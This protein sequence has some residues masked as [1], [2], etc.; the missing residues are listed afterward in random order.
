M[1][2]LGLTAALLLSAVRFLLVVQ[3]Q[4]DTLFK[5]QL[6]MESGSTVRSA[7]DLHAAVVEP[8]PR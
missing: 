2:R 4:E 6:S 5:C 8:V 1:A 3:K 7:C